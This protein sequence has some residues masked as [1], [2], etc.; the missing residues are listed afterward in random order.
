MVHQI[1]RVTLPDG[2]TKDLRFNLYVEYN[3]D[4]QIQCVWEYGGN[5]PIDH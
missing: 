2:T 4:D 1:D 5:A 3:D